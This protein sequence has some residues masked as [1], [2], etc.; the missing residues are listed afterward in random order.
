MG[1]ASQITVVKL[2]GLGNDSSRVV[3]SMPVFRPR[4]SRVRV[5]LHFHQRPMMSHSTDARGSA[6]PRCRESAPGVG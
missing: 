2:F 6:V 3:D 5:A 4:L 1:F